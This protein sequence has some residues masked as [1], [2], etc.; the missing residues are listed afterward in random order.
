MANELKRRSRHT[1]HDQ[2]IIDNDNTDNSDMEEEKDG[3]IN[4]E[5]IP[6]KSKSNIDNIAINNALN[7]LHKEIR[8]LHGLISNQIKFEG[9]IEAATIAELDNML[10]TNINDTNDNL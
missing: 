3:F 7:M 4:I 6:I 9:Q 5:M 1:Y 8:M 10:N 2:K